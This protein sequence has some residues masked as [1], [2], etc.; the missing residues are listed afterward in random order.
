MLVLPGKFPQRRAC[1]TDEVNEKQ[2][3]LEVPQDSR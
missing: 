3:E 2:E 1:N